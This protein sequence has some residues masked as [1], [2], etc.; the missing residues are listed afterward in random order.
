MLKFQLNFKYGFVIFTISGYVRILNF[1]HFY[2]FVYLVYSATLGFNFIAALAYFSKLKF[3][4]KWLEF[5]FSFYEVLDRD[6]ATTFGLSILY[7]VLFIPCSYVGWFRPIYR[8]FRWY[9]EIEW[10]RGKTLCSRADRAM[11]FMI[12]FFIFFFQICISIL[13]V[14]GWNDSGFW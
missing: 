7:L 4:F 2:S 13:M 5:S 12:F 9:R 11:D 6:G 1:N 14:F 8:A 3:I 10:E